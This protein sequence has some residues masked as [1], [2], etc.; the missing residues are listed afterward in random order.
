VERIWFWNQGSSF[1]VAK[2]N[3]SFTGSGSESRCGM[4][5]SEKEMQHRAK[6]PTHDEYQHKKSLA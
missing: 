1:K 6:V 2:S 3:S 5:L 4:V